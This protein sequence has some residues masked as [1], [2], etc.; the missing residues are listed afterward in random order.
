MITRD[1]N[2]VLLNKLVYI[3]MVP[4]DSPLSPIVS[5]V[6]TGPYRF[7]GGKPGSA[8]DGERFEQFW[9]ARP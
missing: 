1:P 4:R 5:P 2:S 8:I 7:V 9:G 6:G 3:A